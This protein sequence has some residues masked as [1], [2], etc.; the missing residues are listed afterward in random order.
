MDAVCPDCHDIMNWQNGETFQCPTCL[1]R[2]VREARC[3]ECQHLLQRLTSCGAVDY[4][5]QQHGMIS[6]KRVLFRYLTAV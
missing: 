1:H 3:P 2:Y 6:K 5:C 4:L